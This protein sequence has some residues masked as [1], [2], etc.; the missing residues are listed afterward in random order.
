[1]KWHIISVVFLPKTHNPSLVIKKKKK[2]SDKFQLRDILQNTL[3][4]LLTTPGWGGGVAQV[5]EC[6][7]G[8]HKA[9]SLNLV[10]LKQKQ[11]LNVL[12]NK[13]KV[14]KCPRP[15]ELKETCKCNKV[16]SVL[17]WNARKRPKYELWL[18]RPYQN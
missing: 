2:K 10:L 13:S 11:T 1:M 5:A 14:R 7:S 4:V 9:L 8:K 17:S 16:S 6:L 12:K 3:P 15:E 18:L